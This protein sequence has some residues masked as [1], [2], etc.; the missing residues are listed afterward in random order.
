MRKYAENP[1]NNRSGL[2]DLIIYNN[3]EYKLVE[4]KRQKEKIR[5]SQIEW[6]LHLKQNSLPAEIIRVKTVK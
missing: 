3:K 1:N 6:L 4:V 5:D 2:P